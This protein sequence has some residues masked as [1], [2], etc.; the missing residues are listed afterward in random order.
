MSLNDAIAVGFLAVSLL[1][2]TVHSWALHK[3]RAGGVRGDFYR[4]VRAR[5]GCAVLYC[6]VGANALWLHFVPLTASFATYAVIQLT[7]M[8]NSRIDVRHGRNPPRQ[9]KH[10]HPR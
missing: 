7:W 9:P 8:H 6:L 10:L 2:L 4:T 3:L 1:S 5:V